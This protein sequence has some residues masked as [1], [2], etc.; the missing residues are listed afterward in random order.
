MQERITEIRNHLS[1]IELTLCNL[2]T[3]QREPFV[4]IYERMD[5]EGTIQSLEREESDLSDELRILEEVSL[6]PPPPITDE[7]CPF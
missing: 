7:P 3:K 4:D 6:L 5:L 2:Y 1:S